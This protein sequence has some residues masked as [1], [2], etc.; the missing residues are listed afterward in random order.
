M[1]VSLKN[2]SPSQDTYRKKP[3]HYA[4]SVA[5]GKLLQDAEDR[6]HQL[7]VFMCVY[8]CARAL[9]CITFRM[10]SFDVGLVAHVESGA[11]RRSVCQTA[12]VSRLRTAAAR[13]RIDRHRRRKGLCFVDRN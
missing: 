1:C 10:L 9:V 13:Q 4:Q 3:S 8:E 2:A 5:V 6:F 12:G 7:Q 11:I